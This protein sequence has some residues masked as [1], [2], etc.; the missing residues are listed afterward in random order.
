MA[1]NINEIR[2]KLALGGARPNLFRVRLT[3]P[4]G[5]GGDVSDA[6]FLIQASALPASTISAIEIPY[7]GRR[8][9][10]AGDREFENWSI[11][12]M[13]DEN[14]KIRHAMEQWHNRINSLSGN[15]NTIGANPS[16]YKSDI[17][18]VD[19]YS[20]AGGNPGGNIIR[21][22]QFFGVFPLS[23]GEI[24]LNWEPS[25]TIE[26]F[27]V[28]FSYDWYQISGGPGIVQ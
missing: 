19:Q 27:P 11:S 5:V 1:F 9:K 2:A 4:S 17:M 22:Y 23:I 21:S 14:F 3:L 25:A 8:V 12:V 7:F 24:E 10:I 6:E 15:V 16:A 13:N 20:K 28:T 18:Y 26:T